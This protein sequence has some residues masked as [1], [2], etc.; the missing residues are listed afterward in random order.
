MLEIFLY[1]IFFCY[2]TLPT[3]FFLHRFS[4]TL[5]I[6]E[7]SFWLGFIWKA[8]S[9]T[10]TS[11]VL[12]VD[13]L[14][15]FCEVFSPMPNS[16]N[17]VACK[18][19]RSCTREHIFIVFNWIK[20]LWM[21]KLWKDLFNWFAPAVRVY[22]LYLRTYSQEWKNSNAAL[23]LFL[24]VCFWKYPCSYTSL[25]VSQRAMDVQQF[26]VTQGDQNLEY[27]LVT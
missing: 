14:Y 6:F 19:P 11:V 12:K 7:S 13:P 1:I 10:N 15:V 2:A 4:L 25:I 23:L 21:R 9:L 26:L 17:S 8:C 5:G 16:I 24:M 22:I 20:K 27:V 3:F 18:G